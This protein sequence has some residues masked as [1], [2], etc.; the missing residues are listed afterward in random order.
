MQEDGWWQFLEL[1]RKFE[2]EKKADAFFDLFFTKEEKAD[3]AKRYLVIRALLNEKL[4][5]RE[6]AKK[7]HVSIFK[8]TRGSNALKIIK[9]TLKEFLIENMK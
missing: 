3:M 2:D 4:S 9:P 5:Q 6:I 1:C 7:Y 8:I